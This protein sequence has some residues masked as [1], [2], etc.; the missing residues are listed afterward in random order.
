MAQLYGENFS[1]PLCFTEIGY[2]SPEGYDEIAENFWWG[3]NTTQAQQ[4][5]WLGETVQ[6]ARAAGNVRLL[7]I[8]N[9]NITTYTST[10]PQGGYAI[11]R[12][13]GTC[14]ACDLL[15]AQLLP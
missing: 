3:A 15:A 5:Q 7:I 6:M 13:D 12:P 2:V 8:W 11:M 1:K 4:A 10:D 14:P 9:L